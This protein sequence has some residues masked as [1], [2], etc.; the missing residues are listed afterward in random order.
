MQMDSG[1]MFKG[2]SVDVCERGGERGEGETDTSRDRLLPC[3]QQRLDSQ[4]ICIVNSNKLE[5]RSNQRL[6]HETF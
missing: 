1:L 5:S 6:R 2:R 4:A 3:H